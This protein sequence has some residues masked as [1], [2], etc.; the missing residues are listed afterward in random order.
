MRLRSH[1]I[2]HRTGG[3]AR[4]ALALALVGSAVRLGAQESP[5][6]TLLMAQRRFAPIPRVAPAVADNPVTPEKLA[7]GRELFGETQLTTATGLSCR[8]CHEP[9]ADHRARPT[10]Q[11]R[12]VP[13]LDNAVFNTL[14]PAAPAATDTSEAP[15]GAA[16]DHP[17]LTTAALHA[18]P[19]VELFAAAFPDEPDP[20]TRD[21]AARALQCYEATL[22]TPGSRFD[23]YLSG[24][25]KQ[26]NGRAAAGLNLFLLQGCSFCHSGVNLGGNGLYYFD[27]F[28]RPA[29]TKALLRVAPLRNVTRTAPY[30]H[31]GSAA[32]LSEAVHIMGDRQLGMT[33]TPEQT[34]DI[35]AFLATL[36][37]P[38][39]RP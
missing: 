25:W 20:I 32:T 23:R 22:I 15:A 10:D 34:E 29:H 17:G 11:A 9:T 1:R 12:D 26:L 27:G 8:D 19:Y 37:G 18:P 6:L 7:L 33:L 4:A 39:P 31:N 5:Y 35:V 38:R 36:A 16:P 30:F 24:D 3:L 21:N 2:P 14:W 28:A 13:T